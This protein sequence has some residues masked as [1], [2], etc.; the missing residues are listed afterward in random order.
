MHAYTLANCLNLGT[1]IYA[2][3]NLHRIKSVFMTNGPEGGCALP[4]DHVYQQENTAH[5]ITFPTELSD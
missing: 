2:H 3:V 4:Q 1:L 5:L